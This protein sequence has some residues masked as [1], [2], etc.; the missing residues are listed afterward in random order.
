MRFSPL[1]F[2][3]IL[4]LLLSG[5]ALAHAALDHAE[6]KVGSTV[7]K[8]PSVV[9]VWLDDDVEADGCTLC[10]CDSHGKEF[11]L[12]DAHRDEKD[13]TLLIVSVPK[14]ADGEYVVTWKVIA[15]DTHKTHGE[16]KFTIKSGG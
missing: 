15:S 2:A 9:K 16:F 5:K 3:A 13:S 4:L 1:K 14:L 6:P 7:G 11:D 12:K 10:V 8:S